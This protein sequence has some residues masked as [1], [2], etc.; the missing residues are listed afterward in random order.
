[1]GAITEG[2][3]PRQGVVKAV[4]QLKP[5]HGDAQEEDQGIGF[6]RQVVPVPYPKK[7]G[8]LNHVNTRVQLSE[9]ALLLINQ[10]GGEG[11]FAG[12]EFPVQPVNAPSQVHSKFQGKLSF[13]VTREQ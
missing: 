4:A 10:I 13:L 1:M 11:E 8:M 9:G 3:K 7:K 6:H 5:V 12:E 2:G